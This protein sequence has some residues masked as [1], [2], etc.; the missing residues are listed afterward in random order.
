MKLVPKILIGVGAV[1]VIGGIAYHLSNS[2]PST[3]LTRDQQALAIFEDG[4]CLMCHSE[5]PDLPF[6]A[7]FP[8]AKGLIQEDIAIGYKHTDLTGLYDAL[9]NG[10]PVDEVTLAKVERVVEKGTMPMARFSMMHWGSAITAKKARMLKA[11]IAEHRAANY[12][13]A[14][15]HAAFAF[16]PV[17]P[18]MDSLPVNPAKVALGKKLYHDTR[19][20]ADNSISCASC[21]ELSTGGVD[22]KQYSDGVGGQKGGVNAPTVYNAALNFVQFWD[23]RAGTLAE[24]AGGPPMNP[25]EMACTS[26]DEII[27]KLKED[28]ELTAEFLAV[29]PD[30]YSGDNL[31]DAIAEFEKTLL[32]PNSRFDRYLKGDSTAMT[33]TEI[34]GYALFKANDCA[35]CHVGA[36]LGGQSYELMGLK[37]DYFA[38][39]G[40]EL[41]V[42]DNGRYKET[43]LERDRHRF[44]TPGLRN[45]ALTAPYLH[46]GTAKTLEEAVD[47]MAVYQVGAPLSTADR[48][49]I[50][51][52]LKTLTG[53]YQGQPLD[54][55][56]KI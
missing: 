44:K 40:L 14:N 13:A 52:F 42:E 56:K 23:G 16:E 37:A 50:V 2:A 45:V 35:T 15:V 5:N 26:W 30:G 1:V 32:T 17:Q 24:Q 51:A 22:N 3:D 10:K 25:V 47:A 29:Y 4:Q 27:V 39:R 53:E 31:T 54:A 11:W 33:P 12:A 20:S 43:Q 28:K 41:T 6:Y 48:D 7:S 18:I 34:E 19:F 9:K 55:M 36:N 21:H 46:D 49:K 38:D 8:V